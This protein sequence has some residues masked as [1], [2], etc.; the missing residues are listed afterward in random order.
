MM[1]KFQVQWAGQHDDQMSEW[2]TVQ[3]T[4]NTQQAAEDYIATQ[5]HDLGVENDE[6]PVIFFRV[7]EVPHKVKY[8]AE[9]KWMEGDL[10]MRTAHAEDTLSLAVSYVH[11]RVNLESCHEL[12]FTKVE[13]DA[14]E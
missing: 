6:E 14:Y 9:W 4:F 3:I 7:Y 12:T 10:E 2:R 13:Y 1:P 11:Q 8:R 5:R